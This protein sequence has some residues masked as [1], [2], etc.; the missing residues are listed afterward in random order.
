MSTIVLIH[1]AMQTSDT[2]DRVVPFLQRAGLVVFTPELSGMG[3]RGGPMTAGVTLDT[4]IDDVVRF[5]QLHDL[6][7][8]VL[9]GH[10]YSGMVI[11]GVAARVPERIGALVYLDAFVPEQGQAAFGFMPKPIQDLFQSLVA[12]DGFRIVASERLLEIWHVQ[13]SAREFVADRL[14]D[15]SMRCF[16]QPL[17][18]DPSQVDVPRTFVA[19]IAEGYRARP[20]FAPFA[21][22][23]KRE[24]W[25][26][27]ELP[28]GHDPQVDLPDAVSDVIAQA[29][30]AASCQAQ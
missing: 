8:V 23:A 22:R 2:W 30:R 25:D 12:A 3:P 24:G 16:T 15:F 1:G 13:E 28:A 6:R 29:A 21:E 14:W 10:S 11:T 4:H 17:R 9:V 7:H 20:I 27:H 19:C 26:Y 18:E 5:L